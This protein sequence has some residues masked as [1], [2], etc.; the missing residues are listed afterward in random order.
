MVAVGGDADCRG[1]KSVYYRED[2]DL[3]DGLNGRREHARMMSV[4]YSE[5]SPPR[6]DRGNIRGRSRSPKM[7]HSG[8]HYT[9]F[10]KERRAP[11]S[12]SHSPVMQL[13]SAARDNGYGTLSDKENRRELRSSY[14]LRSPS[15]IEIR[16]HEESILVEEIRGQTHGR[17]GSWMEPRSTEDSRERRDLREEGHSRRDFRRVGSPSPSSSSR[18]SRKHESGKSRLSYYRHDLEDVRQSYRRDGSMRDGRG[19]MQSSSPGS[20]LQIQRSHSRSPPRLLKYGGSS[21]SRPRSRSQSPNVDRRIESS[22]NQRSGGYRRHGE[23]PIGS[24]LPDERLSLQPERLRYADE[25]SI[26][27]VARDEQ[28]ERQRFFQQQNQGRRDFHDADLSRYGSGSAIGQGGGGRG[29]KHHAHQFRGARDS[30]LYRQE[31]APP[32]HRS[33]SPLPPSAHHR[34]ASP[35]PQD[36]RH[37][38]TPLQT[39]QHQRESFGRERRE[40]IAPRGRK[41]KFSPSRSPALHGIYNHRREGPSD[42]HEF[43]PE[44]DSL[45]DRN[46]RRRHSRY[47]RSRDERD[48]RSH[49]RDLRE[50]RSSRPERSLTPSP[51]HHEHASTS[52]GRK[53]S[54]HSPHRSFNRRNESDNGLEDASGGIKQS[55]SK[56]EGN[57]EPQ[58]MDMKNEGSRMARDELFAGMDDLTVDYEE[59][60]E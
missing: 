2:D 25:R 9:G 35:P 15:P 40:E 29:E 53:S 16:S 41:S 43:D 51:I 52:S 57:V 44:A 7:H 26:A 47:D 55:R 12:R 19:R 30:D 45:G 4:K 24:Q 60:D 20:A 59:D 33:L 3:V 38:P 39:S 14:G 50:I 31:L 11:R 8:G 13:N 42:S 56:S 49:H 5:R 27:E 17:G 21:T 22:R 58:Q 34:S 32:Q 37:P 23:R 18:R 48:H 1:N 36:H 28:Q 54:G 6:S 10:S 46:E